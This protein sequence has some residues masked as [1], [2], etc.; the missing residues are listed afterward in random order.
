MKSG[1]LG[2]GKSYLL[3]C[4]VVSAAIHSTLLLSES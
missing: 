3:G 2:G 4:D 1:N